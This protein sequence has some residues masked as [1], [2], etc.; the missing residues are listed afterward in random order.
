MDLTY[1]HSESCH[2]VQLPAVVCILQGL[3][4]LAKIFISIQTFT[5]NIRL[6]LFF[7]FRHR[8]VVVPS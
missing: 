1:F 8:N 6:G 3:F 5:Q 2:V 7:N 4:L